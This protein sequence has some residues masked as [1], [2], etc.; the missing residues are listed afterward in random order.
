MKKFDVCYQPRY[1]KIYVILGPKIVED[2]EIFYQVI[3]KGVNE[4]NNYYIYVNDL[5]KIG[6][7]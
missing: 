3:G 7:L 1:N 5:V 6:A 4:F 2:N